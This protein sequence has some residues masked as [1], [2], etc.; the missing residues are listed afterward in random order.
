MSAWQENIGELPE[1]ITYNTS[2]DVE[3]RDGTIV[4]NSHGWGYYGYWELRKENTD[5]I[6]WRFA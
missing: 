1:G 6:R 2:L 3:Y 5:I 4:N